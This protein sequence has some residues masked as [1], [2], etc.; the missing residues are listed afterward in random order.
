MDGAGYSLTINPSGGIT[1]AV[2]GDGSLVKTRSTIAVND[3]AW[4]HVIAE[5][6][7]TTRILA[8]YIDGKKNNESPG[9]DGS[10]SLANPSDLYVGGTPQG[11]CLHGAFDF[12]R[13]SLG[14]LKDAKTDIAEL[15]AWQFDGPFL[16]DFAGNAPRGDRDAGALEKVD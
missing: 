8:I 2:S 6:D 1:F 10:V 16:R 11:D 15:Y 9:I 3:G 4:H 5:C 13:I 7:R 12:L 14:T